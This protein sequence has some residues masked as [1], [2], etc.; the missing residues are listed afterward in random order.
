MP[1]KL[2]FI[3]ENPSLKRELKDGKTKIQLLGAQN[4]E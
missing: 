2:I 4:L 1:E 3:L